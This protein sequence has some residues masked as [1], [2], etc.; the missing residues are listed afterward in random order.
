MQSDKNWSYRIFNNGDN[1]E[2]NTAMV[3]KIDKNGTIEKFINKIPENLDTSNLTSMS[4]FFQGCNNLEKIP[5]IDTSN[6]TNFQNCFAGCS[7]IKQMPQIDTS[8]ST[9]MYSCFSGCLELE[10]IPS[11]DTSNVT[12]FQSCFNECAK[13]KQIPQIDT[14]KG[15]NLGSLFKECRSI[16]TIPQIDTANATSMNDLFYNC[17]NITDIPSLNASKVTSIYNMLSGC[18]NLTDF[19]GLIELGKAFTA[20]SN[21]YNNYTFNLRSCTNLTHESLVNIINNLYDLNLTYDT[22]NGGTL[23]KQAFQLGKDNLAKLTADEI[24]IATNKGWNV[25]D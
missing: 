11:I 13:L 14:S 16:T 2:Y 17:S 19:N 12:N 4:G 21:N 18:K 23:Y 6:S 10:S 9:T 15:T 20:K 1:S 25:T 3:T 8:K 24:L 22:A 7:K 5:N